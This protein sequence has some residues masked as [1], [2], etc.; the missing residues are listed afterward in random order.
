MPRKVLVANRGEIAVRILRACRELG[1]ETVAVYSDVDRSALHV[2]Y[3]D[4]SYLLG[5][6]PPRE[7]YLSTARLLEIARR[8]GAN[9]VHPGYGFLAENAAFARA[10][11]DAGLI[12]IGPSPEVIALMGDKIA[13][14]Q[15][16]QAANIPV[17]PGTAPGL[18]KEELETV[19]GHIGYPLLVKAAAGGGGKGMHIVHSAA[20]LPGAIAVA[21]REAEAAF[22]DGSIYL[23]RIIK[24]A[25][26]IEFQILGDQHGNVIHLGDRECSI[27]RRYQKLVE[28]A[29]AVSLT[30]ALRREMGRVALQAAKAVGYTNAGTVEF[31]LDGQG[32]FYFLE[33]NTRLQ[34][35]HCV[36]EAVTGVDIVREQLRIA[37]GRRLRLRQEEV[38]VR[39]C[40]IECRITAEDPYNQFQPSIGRVTGLYEPTGPGIRLDSSIYE[41]FD[42]SPYYDSLVSKLVAW[43]DT[44]AEAI[45]RMRRALEE[46]RI[47]GV[48]TTIPFHQELMDSARFIGG[49]FDT[50]FI[51]ESFALVEEELEE[52]LSLAAIAATLLTHY[53]RHEAQAEAAAQDRRSV[54]SW[55]MSGRW[56]ALGWQ[57]E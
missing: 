26:H 1:L 33:M 10:C 41:G 32:N 48:K 24:D 50:T 29:P 51:E 31:L 12:F 47:I 22:G 18:D 37:A 44:R 13:A 19:A 17:A 49:Q 25:R 54:S 21:Q 28:E 7:S 55:K 46:Y 39:G 6:A 35:E 52:H 36:T 34:V 57:R 56:Q 45:L 14:R 30:D 8:S 11:R 43:G 4:E 2:R 38:Q 27:Q 16:M 42:I 15:T 3:A 23:E 40:A 5:P 53:R 9:A 20:G